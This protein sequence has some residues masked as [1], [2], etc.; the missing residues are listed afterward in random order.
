MAPSGSMSE[1]FLKI[2]FTFAPIF[3]FSFS[4][5]TIWLNIFALLSS[6][7]IAKKYGVSLSKPKGPT[8]TSVKEIIFPVNG[9]SFSTRIPFLLQFGQ[10]GLGGKKL[11]LQFS[12]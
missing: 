6:S 11:V 1:I 4:E 5:S 8:K 3:I 10:I 2:F 7:I 9:M 12:Q